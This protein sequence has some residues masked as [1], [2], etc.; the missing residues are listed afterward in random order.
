MSGLFSKP[1]TVKPG[2]PK[3]APP[4]PPVVVPVEPPV[5]PPVGPPVLDEP[6]EPEESKMWL[7]LV[8]LGAFAGG[9]FGFFQE[10]KTEHMDKPV[11]SSSKL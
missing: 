10:Y 6:E 2:T 3:P 8:A 5:E 1:K 11:P 7:L 9:A 4:K